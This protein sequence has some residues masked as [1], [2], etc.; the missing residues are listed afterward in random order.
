MTSATVWALE[1]A[2]QNEGRLQ[3]DKWFNEPVAGGASAF[4]DE[5]A[6]VQESIVRVIKTESGLHHFRDVSQF[7]PD[8][9]VAVLDSILRVELLL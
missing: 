5:T 6:C 9:S 3:F 4:E 8:Q 7:V 2:S 1:T